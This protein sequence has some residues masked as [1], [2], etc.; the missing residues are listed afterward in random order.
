MKILTFDP[1]V[2]EAGDEILPD[3]AGRMSIVTLADEDCPLHA[4]F[5]VALKVVAW[6]TGTT[7]L[8]DDERFVPTP[9]TVTNAV[10]SDVVHDTRTDSFAQTALDDDVIVTTGDL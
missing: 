5:A 2:V 3:G 7:A 6:A 8:P 1:C 4:V 10:G 9:S